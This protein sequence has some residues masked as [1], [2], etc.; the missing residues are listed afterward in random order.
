MRL[1]LEHGGPGVSVSK[2]KV[3]GT[4][5][6]RREGSAGSGSPAR[7]RFDIVMQG[8]NETAFLQL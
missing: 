8:D 3:R 6:A 5:V 2:L 7:Y 4:L 1:S